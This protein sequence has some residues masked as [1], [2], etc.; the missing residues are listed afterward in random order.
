MIEGLAIK[1]GGLACLRFLLLLPL[2]SEAMAIEEVFAIAVETS[3]WFVEEIEV[4]FGFCI[5]WS[6]FGEA[7]G[8]G[9]KSSSEAEFAIFKVTDNKFASSLSLK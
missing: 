3:G 9:G 5:D 4:S 8:V 2:E 6:R 7:G 1:D